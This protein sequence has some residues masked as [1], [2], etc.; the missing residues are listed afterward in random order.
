ML[1]RAVQLTFPNQTPGDDEIKDSCMASHYL[2]MSMHGNISVDLPQIRALNQDG[3]YLWNDYRKLII[4]PPPDLRILNL[5]TAVTTSI[6]N[7][8]IPLWKL[9]YHFHENNAAIALHGYHSITHSRNVDATPSPVV[10]TFANNHVF[11]CGKRAFVEETLPCF[12]TLRKKSHQQ[13][14]FAGSGLN[15]SDAS[16]PASI[17]LSDEKVKIFAVGCHDSGVPSS[18]S[19][20]ASEPGIFYIGGLESERDVNAAFDIITQAV[21]AYSDPKNDL[22]ILSIHWGPN[23]AY[24]DGEDKA[25]QVHRRKLAHRLI[26][27][28]GV[29]LIYGHSSHHVRGIEVYNNKLILYGAGDLI[30]DYEGFSNPGEEKYSSFGGIFLADFSPRTHELVDLHIVPMFMNRL[31]LCRWTENSKQ[32]NPNHCRMEAKHHGAQE[33]CDFINHLSNLDA[34]DKSKALKLIVSRENNVVPGAPILRWKET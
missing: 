34:A 9:R 19:A 31:Q 4:T 15:L 14:Q 13:I 1:G 33:F 8:D 23:W 5:E 29:D 30:N 22:V 32:Y 20:T 21:R 17:S 27:E 11:D 28:A 10:V 18:W 25:E 16:M 6:D 12:Q 2:T 7:R 26:D 24:R 3:A